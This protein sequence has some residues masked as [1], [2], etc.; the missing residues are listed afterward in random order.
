[1]SRPGRALQD[2]VADRFEELDSFEDLGL[3]LGA[4]PFEATAIWPG[5][6]S[7]P[8]VGQALDLEVVVKRLDLLR[9]RDPEP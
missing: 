7:G 6:A 8:E 2:P 3:G 1:M 5:L 4:K 9:A